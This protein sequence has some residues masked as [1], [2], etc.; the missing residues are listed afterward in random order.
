MVFAFVAIAIFLV[1][2]SLS[3]GKDNTFFLIQRN[4]YEK[5]F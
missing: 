5:F 1:L 4:F 2:W 3:D